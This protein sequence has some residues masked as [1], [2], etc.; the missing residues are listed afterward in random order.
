MEINLKNKVILVT[1]ASSGIGRS[2]VLR[3][4]QT[5]ATIALHYNKN[6]SGAAALQKAAG[7]GSSIF[8][9]DLCSSEET[10][11]LYTDVKKTYGKIDVVINNAGVYICSPIENND[12]Q[13][14]DHWNRTMHINLLAAA[15]LCKYAVT[16]FI[17]HGG[18]RIINIASRAAFRGDTQ[19]YWAYAASKGGLVSLTRTIARAYGKQKV[20][21]FVVAPGFVRTKMAQEC[22]DKNG[23]TALV[24]ETALGM[25]T[26]PDEVAPTVVFLASGLMDHATG[27]SIDINAGS[28]VR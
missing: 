19:D 28:Y 2:I 4:A 3:L 20:Y 8:K 15:M 22:I 24:N 23:E 18:G 10:R 11:Q 13:W 14:L 16:D 6:E 5:D 27:C 1:G 9:A 7:N 21:A 17:S 25:L 26:Q 12:T